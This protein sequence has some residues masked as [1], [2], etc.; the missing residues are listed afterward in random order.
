LRRLLLVTAAVVV[1]LGVA[2]AAA[3]EPEPV[4]A[5]WT[6][7]TDSDGRNIDEVGVA[8]TEDGVLHV[9]W[10]KRTGPSQ[11]EIRHTP[12]SATGSVGASTPAAIGFASVEN[13]A[14]VVM[15][16]GSLRMF[17]GGLT[18]AAGGRDG[19][20]SASAAPDAAASPWTLTGA[21][22]SSTRSAIPDGVGAAVKPDGT[23]AF[24]YAYSF[25][26]GFHVG[27]NS[28]ETDLDLIGSNAC[29]GYNPQVAFDADGTGYVAWFSNVEGQ[30]GTYVQEVT[31]SLGDQVLAPE[32]ATGGKALATSQRT[33]LVARVGG[34]VYLAY[35][36]GYPTCTRVLLWKV[37]AT[38]PVEV[39]T[40]TDVEAV[41]L[42]GAPD[43]R[44]WITWEDAA[45]GTLYSTRTDTD[46]K[47]VAS[48]VPFTPPPGTDTVWKLTTDATDSEVAVLAAATVRTG[49]T[50]GLATWYTT[51]E[52]G[53]TVGV[54]A[55]KKHTDY[56]VTDFGKPVAGV[57]IV[58]GS[59]T[60]T[61]DKKGTAT[62]ARA[63]ATVEV[64]KSGYATLTIPTSST[65]GA[66][67]TPTTTARPVATTTTR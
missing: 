64:S 43:G 19:V 11:E 60:L 67:G 2:P 57:K 50:T 45:T 16:D 30:V 36:S 62:G 5:T 23:P 8:R 34:G 3:T 1:L 33:P 51:V 49:T 52:P 42:A 59:K 55:T 4:D 39:A 32:S 28:A 35:C 17:F 47:A 54:K 31:P 21:R 25:V 56:T 61:T 15:P 22:V 13:P 41:T 46:A 27:L 38:T 63:P 65:A 24:T 9:L 29:C 14:V 20:Q 7:V 18:V 66:A 48:P 6:Q 40:G 53:L 12:I 26:V 37:G 10:R 58:A 44:L